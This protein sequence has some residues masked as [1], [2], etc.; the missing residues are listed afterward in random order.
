MKLIGTHLSPFLLRTLFCARLKGV[1]IPTEPPTSD[2]HSPEFR[3]VN[4]LGKVPVLIDGDFVLPESAA[5]CEYLEDKLPGRSIWPLDLQARAR[6]RM[7]CEIIDLYLFMDMCNCFFPDMAPGPFKGA[8]ERVATWLDAIEF[9]LRPDSRWLAGEQP[10]MAD[11]CMATTLFYFD[12]VGGPYG[13]PAWLALRPRL[14]SWW[15]RAKADP[16]LA[17]I[18]DEQRIAFEAQMAGQSLDTGH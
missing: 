9:Y 1:E 4:P 12:A 13:G 17:R 2:T 6:A 7:L 8:P 3:K 10:S 5:I 15:A 18:Y 11:V 16:A 14:A